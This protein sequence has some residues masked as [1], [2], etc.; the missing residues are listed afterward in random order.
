MR[1]RWALR[2]QEAGEFKARVAMTTIC[3]AVLQDI[4]AVLMHQESEVLTLAEAARLS[5][6]SPGHLG[7]LIRSGHIDSAGRSGAPRIRRCNLPIKPG[8]LPEGEA[9]H[10]IDTASKEHVVR[11]FVANSRE[12]GNTK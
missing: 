5:G 2:Q 6:F 10:Q 7:R 4:D 8:H 12:R 1:E 9:S 11:S 3:E